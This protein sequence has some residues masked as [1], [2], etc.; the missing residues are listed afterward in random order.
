MNEL[1]LAGLLALHPVQEIGHMDVSARPLLGARATWTVH[2]TAFGGALGVEGEPPQA[3]GA[4]LGRLETDQYPGSTMRVEA[5]HR[6]DRYGER[7]YWRMTLRAARR[8]P[9]WVTFERQYWTEVLWGVQAAPEA[10]PLGRRYVAHPF[11]EAMY[12]TR[13]GRRSILR[14][15]VLRGVGVGVSLAATF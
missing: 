13:V 3:Y 5:E 11:R 14:A 8:S 10:T 2:G 7:R 9:Y 12:L 15:G 4:L 1:L 6:W